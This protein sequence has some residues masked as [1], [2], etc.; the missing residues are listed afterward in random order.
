LAGEARR[1]KPAGDVEEVTVSQQ[2]WFSV[3]PP[4]LTKRAPTETSYAVVS[5]LSVTGLFM[6]ESFTRRTLVTTRL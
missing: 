4:T 3:Y 1:L 5:S 2:S 6:A